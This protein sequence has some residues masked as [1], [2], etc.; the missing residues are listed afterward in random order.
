M[1]SGHCKA[2]SYNKM[3]CPL[4]SQPRIE[5]VGPSN[6]KRKAMDKIALI[7]EDEDELEC[8]NETIIIRP[9]T[10]CEAKIRLQMKKLHQLPTGSRKVNFSGEESGVSMP[11]NLSY[12][13]RKLI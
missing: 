12:S 9:R 11:I 8:E 13:P 3:N 4:T 10:I 2:T 6:S 5:V 7:D 1:S